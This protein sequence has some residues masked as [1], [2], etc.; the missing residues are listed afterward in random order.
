MNE[1]IK[2]YLTLIGYLTLSNGLGYFA[3]TYLAKD[4]ALTAIFGP[5]I[6]L[7]IYLLRKELSKEGIVRTALKK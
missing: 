5:S 1:T 7:I 6:N 3:A 4:P 2:K